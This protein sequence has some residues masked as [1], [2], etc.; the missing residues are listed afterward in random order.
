[1]VELKLLVEGVTTL[2]AVNAVG[3][4]HDKKKAE[5]DAGCGCASDQK[6]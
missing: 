6:V 2:V 4:A 5:P 3:V 1:M